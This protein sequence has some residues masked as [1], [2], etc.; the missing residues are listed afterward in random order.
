[1][2]EINSSKRIYHANDLI[3]FNEEV[4][5][6]YP[7]VVRSTQNNGVR[8]YIIQDEEFLNPKNTISFAQD[9]FSV[10]FQEKPYYT[11]NKVKV[12]VPKFNKWNRNIALYISSICQKSLEKFTWGTGSTVN[13]IS[14]I[15]VFIPVKNGEIDFEFID[16]FISELEEERIS[17]L[18]AYLTVSGLDNYELSSEEKEA[19]NNIK[20]IEY[21]EFNLENLFGKAT[22]G[23]RLKGEDR[24]PGNLPFVTAGEGNT[25][26]SAF[27]GNNVEVFS[28][29]TVTI[30]MFG[31]AKYRNYKYGADDH[32]AVVHTENIQKETT[33]FITA[34]IH[35][36][37]Y[38]G[39]FNYGRNFYAKDADNLSIMLPIKNNKI[40]F[41]IM[42]TLISA[43]QKLVI[44]D[45]V[46]YADNKIEATKNIVENNK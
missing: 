19:I 3:I 32:I 22:R 45:V 10:F 6:S 2:F 28:N 15:K 16:A 12:L 11:G 42:K 44:K 30:D 27:I 41:D 13:S 4:K 21:E 17:E 20:N 9:T 1:M 5:N 18:A 39:Q 24:I 29:N 26:I 34:A 7:Y 40:D 46:K 43:V 8:G 36:S 38:N 33:I 37:S 31:S 35:K 23:K 25:G 14:N